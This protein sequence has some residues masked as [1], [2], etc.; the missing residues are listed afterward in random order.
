M[1]GPR[2]ELNDLVVGLPVYRVR[3]TILTPMGKT[4]ASRVTIAGSHTEDQ[5][6]NEAE[7]T[8]CLGANPSQPQQLFKVGRLTLIGAEQN[9]PYAIGVEVLSSE[10]MT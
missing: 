2:E 5:L 8:Y 1:Y 7:G 3:N 4:I 6:G 10:V 9:L